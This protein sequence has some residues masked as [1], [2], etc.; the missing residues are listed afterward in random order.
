MDGGAAKAGESRRVARL[1]LIRHARHERAHPRILDERRQL[2]DE[3]QPLRK[4][5]VEIAVDRRMVEPVECGIQLGDS[6]TDLLEEIGGLLDRSEG[7][8]RQPG[9]HTRVMTDTGGRGYR[10]NP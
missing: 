3:R 10:G 6:R 7:H 2:A 4:V 8:A 5:P 1:D 9:Q